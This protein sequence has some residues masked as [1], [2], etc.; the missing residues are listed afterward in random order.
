MSRTWILTWNSRM[1]RILTVTVHPILHPRG[2]GGPYAM[3]GCLQ[4]TVATTSR[5]SPFLT[6]KE[7]LRASSAGYRAR[8]GRESELLGTG[9]EPSAEQ[10]G[11]V[12]V[13][14]SDLNRAPYST[15]TLKLRWALVTPT[16]QQVVH[17]MTF[18]SADGSRLLSIV[19]PD[20]KILKPIALRATGQVD[21]QTPL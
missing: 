11:S 15:K 6:V 18:G 1:L 8:R 20:S 17:D 10:V 19:N 7:T 5:T 4:D 9:A 14:A 2:G 21:N 3:C 12:T 16:E 13:P